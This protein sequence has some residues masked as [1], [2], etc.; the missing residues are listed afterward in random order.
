MESII[1]EDEKVLCGECRQTVGKDGETKLSFCPRCG[2]PL[3]LP[4]F[5]KLESKINHEKILTLYEA[6]DEIQDG[7]DAIEVLKEFIEELKD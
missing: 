7:R 3:N 4:A 5:E 6:I 2:N 1:F